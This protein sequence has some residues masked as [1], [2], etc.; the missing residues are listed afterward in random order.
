[1]SVAPRSALRDMAP[2]FVLFALVFGAAALGQCGRCADESVQ[3]DWHRRC[4]NSGGTVAETL[5]ARG[6]EGW[7]CLPRSR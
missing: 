3:S 7:V 1:M 4:T 6:I 5:T 2:V